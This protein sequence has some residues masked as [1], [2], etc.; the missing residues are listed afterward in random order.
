MQ[1]FTVNIIRVVWPH[2][3][4]PLDLRHFCQ[5]NPLFYHLN[6]I[7]CHYWSW[8]R[9]VY[10]LVNIFVRHTFP[11][12][13]SSIKTKTV[14]TM[15][16]MTEST[17]L[18]AF[19]RQRDGYIVT[20]K[21][22]LCIYVVLSWDE[23]KFRQ[24]LPD[25]DYEIYMVCLLVATVNWHKSLQSAKKSNIALLFMILLAV[26]MITLI[27]LYQILARLEFQFLYFL[28]LNISVAWQAWHRN[29]KMSQPP[30]YQEMSFF[31][32]CM[33]SRKTFQESLHSEN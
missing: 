26:S 24:N 30:K 14:L 11:M 3:T 19:K 21:I 17:K 9:N 15:T 8:K 22:S 16:D 27:M 20:V 12:S 2:V 31:P 33:T 6:L 32:L 25:S 13:T 28:Y 7:P 10:F 5:R 1:I 4:I 18:Q 29:S 23:L